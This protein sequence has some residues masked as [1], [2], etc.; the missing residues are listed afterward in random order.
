MVSRIYSPQDSP[1][2]RKQQVRAHEALATL[3]RQ[4]IADGTYPP[5]SV[6]PAESVLAETFGLSRHIVRTAKRALV[7]D[8]LLESPPGDILTFVC[9]E[10]GQSVPNYKQELANTLRRRL[11]QGVYAP[12]TR[13][14]KTADLARE[15]GVG[16]AAMRCAINQI[17]EEG[18][19]E[20][21]GCRT[22]VTAQGP[23]SVPAT[24]PTSPIPNE[25]P[26]DDSCD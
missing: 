15:F 4:K 3:L 14:P 16:T 10:P 17:S 25:T 12:G 2:G 11:K 5:G 24:Q 1:E 26:C 23:S 21:H 19:L 8:G 6:F 22:Y 20:T 7:R 18:H 13:I 9:V